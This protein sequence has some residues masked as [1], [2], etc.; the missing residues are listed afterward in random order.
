MDE[1][2]RTNIR[3]TASGNP[4]GI[5][6]DARLCYVG[7][8]RAK[9]HLYLVRAFRRAFSGH[10]P[11]SRFL[12][13]IPPILAAQSQRATQREMMPARYRH[14]THSGTVGARLDAPLHDE[15][16]GPP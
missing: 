8:T 5:G 4:D 12:A 7:M 9:R 2:I 13:D 14:G 15:E 10:H 16:P 3:S 1:G 6:E 11:A